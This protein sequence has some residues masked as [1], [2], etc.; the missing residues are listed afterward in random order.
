MWEYVV[1][2]GLGIQVVAG[3][4]VF[5]VAMTV[6]LGRWT[7]ADAS[8]LGVALRATALLGIAVVAFTRFGTIWY[9]LL[10]PLAVLPLLE[11]SCGSRLAAGWLN[12][13][14]QERLSEAAVAAADHATNAVNRVHLA[15]SLLETGQI[16]VGLAALDAAVSIADEQS[17]ERLQEMA[18][19]ARRDFLKQCPA[20]R[21]PNRVAARVCSTC[22]R[23]L[24][25]DALSRA[26]VWVSRPALR[27]LP[28]PN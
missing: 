2:F 12:Q 10:L 13:K 17:R 5:A 8:A 4:L 14:R 6:L 25:D 26:L 27:L 15:R 21:A 16:D 9:W 23:A 7:T 1:A 20:C 3:L 28:R 18:D 22:L 19:E 11:F 24:R